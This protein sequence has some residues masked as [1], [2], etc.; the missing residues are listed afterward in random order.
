MY[1]WTFAF[2][3]T[4]SWL[5]ERNARGRNAK[6]T[7]ERQI[8]GFRGHIL[9]HNLKTMWLMLGHWHN[10][11]HVWPIKRHIYSIPFWETAFQ[12]LFLY[13]P[14]ISISV[15]QSVHTNMLLKYIMPD[16]N[17]HLHK[18]C[19][20]AHKVYTPSALTQPAKKSSLHDPVQIHPVIWGESLGDL[21]AV[22]SP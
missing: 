19:I 5:D 21:V 14:E 7:P 6:F 18:P 13:T 2:G 12:K 3:W 4:D 15:A 1:L 17:Y 22:P 20:H 16:W 11:R 8:S 9:H 10:H